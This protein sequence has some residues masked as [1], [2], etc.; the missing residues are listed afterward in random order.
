MRYPENLRTVV[1]VT[2]PPYCAD[3]TGKTDCT[4][5]LIKVFNDIIEEDVA[6]VRQTYEKLK[7]APDGV[8]TYIGFQSRKL[9]WGLLNVSYSEDLPPARVM[10][11]PKGT[12]LV[13]DTIVYKTRKSRKFHFG[14]FFYELNRNIHFEGECMEET[15]I[16]LKDNAKGFEY[17]QVRPVINFHLRT[18]S[19]Y[20]HCA[21]NAMLNTVK[22]LTIDC[23]K[24]N[25]GAAG[26]KY[27]ANNTGRIENVTIKSSD[28]KG[29]GFAGIMLNG[30]G[31]GRFN[32]IT[33]SGFDYGVMC[34]DTQR[35]LFENITLENQ[36]IEG[37]AI[38]TACGIFKDIKSKNT[39]PTIWYEKSRRKGVTS[40]INIEGQVG[41]DTNC[42]VYMRNSKG[43]SITKPV[44]KLKDKEN[45]KISLNLPIEDTPVYQ[46]DH[47]SEWVCVD[48]FG[49]KGDGV[50]D[51]TVAIQKALNSGA[52][53]VYFNQ[54][55]YLV[56]DEIHIPASVE[57][58]NFCLCDMAV[59]QKFIDGDG[60][61]AFVIDED[62]NKNLF[63]QNA[64]F[65][66]RFYGK[67][68]FIRHSAKRDLVLR[69][70]HIQ[71]GHI[72]FNTVPGSRVFIDDVAC[73]SGDFSRWYIE[74]Y[75]RVEREPIYARC[76][77]F[78]FH[79]QKVF[80]RNI[81]PERAD[82]HIVNDGGQV[83]LLGAYTEGP[84]TVIKTINGGK[85]EIINF[86]SHIANHVDTSDTPTI[87]ND[88]SDVSAVSGNVSADRKY[89]I[90]EISDTIQDVVIEQ[91][92]SDGNIHG[93]IGQLS[94]K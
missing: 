35:T 69:D 90:R 40:L 15:V 89:V 9:D 3:N 88:K 76:I 19:F 23:G 1:D 26:I 59:G 39:V 48:D 75:K 84:G 68:R 91:L 21:N 61:G 43:D 83:I 71:T 34:I 44:I 14:R 11:F 86:M 7:N 33:I 72:Y 57:M 78:E 37:I 79:G 73:T 92:G 38:K 53:T 52:R 64:F 12:Y 2:K 58:I 66:E 55:R 51:S 47:I 45:N 77:P 87:V 41:G 80:A 24:G 46:Y 54:G 13:S 74:S 31:I 42:C 30:H 49:A 10:Y 50:T 94:G 56:T 17:G 70:N 65:W 28:P 16:K 5:I 85:T 62:S 29:A 6:L 18:E 93:Y 60:L 4:D 27:Y 81:N 82:L 63:M 32:D 25:P 20:D 67:F 8:N 36:R 22:D